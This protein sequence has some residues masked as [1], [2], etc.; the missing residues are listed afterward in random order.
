MTIDRTTKL[1]LAALVVGVWALAVPQFK[2]QEFHA[3]PSPVLG[4]DGVEARHQPVSEAIPMPRAASSSKPL[5][6]RIAVAQEVVGATGVNCITLIHVANPG[7]SAVSVDVEWFNAS[8][9]TEALRTASVSAYTSKSFVTDD[10]VNPAPFFQSNTADLE[11]F[12]SGYANVN[13]DDPRIVVSAYLICKDGIGTSNLVSMSLVPA[14]P[15]G[16]TAEYFQAGMPADWSPPASHL[17]D[18]DLPQ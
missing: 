2:I 6:W 15:M 16:A 18:R 9:S 14:Y 11:N 1:L 17:A 12:S 3:G 8:G 4:P 7:S 5:R 10:Q 13:A